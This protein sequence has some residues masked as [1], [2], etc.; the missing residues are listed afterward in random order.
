LQI[1]RASWVPAIPVAAFL[2]F[3]FAQGE[4]SLAEIRAEAASASAKVAVGRQAAARDLEDKHNREQN[5]L[6]AKHRAMLADARLIAGTEASERH[7]DEWKR[8]QNHDPSS[9]A[10]LLAKTLV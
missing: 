1:P 5:E 3:Q 9:A 10:S 4:K 2:W 6:E 8:R 7:A